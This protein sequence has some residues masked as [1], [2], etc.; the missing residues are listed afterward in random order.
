MET[1]LTRIEI[2]G[3]EAKLM[4]TD[5]HLASH[6]QE[7]E[8][9]LKLALSPYLQEV[10]RNWV[11]SDTLTK[12]LRAAA[13]LDA[14]ITESGWRGIGTAL[15]AIFKHQNL[16][17]VVG[18]FMIFGGV[19]GFGIAWKLGAPNRLILERNQQVL[20]FCNQNW[21]SKPPPSGWYTCPIWQLPVP[22]KK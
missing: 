11:A 9:S 12:E 15:S 13:I 18:I 21:V 7:L 1:A 22:E 6:P 5:S 8:N 4:Q 20:E 19:L 14:N 2:A 10:N 16:T 3:L 17:V